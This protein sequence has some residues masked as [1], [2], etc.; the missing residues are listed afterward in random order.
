MRKQF[1]QRTGRKCEMK[2]DVIESEKGNLGEKADRSSGG[3]P[4][5]EGAW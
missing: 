3:L 1:E 4:N 5:E 2:L